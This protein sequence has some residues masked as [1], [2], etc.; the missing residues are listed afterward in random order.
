M[1][2]CPYY[3][4]TSIFHLL[5]VGPRFPPGIGGGGR[6]GPLD[7]SRRCIAL[8]HGKGGLLLCVIMI[9]SDNNS[10]S[11]AVKLSIFSPDLQQRNYHYN[12]DNKKEIYTKFK[13]SNRQSVGG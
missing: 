11:L 7:N 13:R 5:G 4:D 12:G 9:A 8:A 6:D 1:Y 10:S 3:F 2:R